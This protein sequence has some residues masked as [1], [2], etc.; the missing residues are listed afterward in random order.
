M[1]LSVR[2]K[3]EWPQNLAGAE[4]APKENIVNA[5]HVVGNRNCTYE[6]VYD[7]RYSRRAGERVD[8]RR[9]LKDR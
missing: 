3:F 8:Q 4:L 9:R 6:S 7:W 1:T 2:R 5:I